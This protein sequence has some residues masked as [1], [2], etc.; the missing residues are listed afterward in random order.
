MSYSISNSTIENL[1]SQI[2]IVDVIGSCVPLKRAGSNYKGVC[3]F[4]N[5]KTP[6]FVVSEQKQ[7]F[8]CFGCGATGNVI[9]FVMMYYNMNF[10]EAVEKLAGEYGITIE[11]KTYG[12][13]LDIYYKTNKLAAQFFYRAFT[14]TANKGYAYMKRRGISPSTLKKFGIGYADESWHSLVDFLSSQGI[15]KKIMLELGLAAESKGRIYDKF[16]NRVMF[17]IINTSGKV[18][19]FGGR[20]IASEDNPKYLNSPE[21]KVFKKKNNL[22]GLNISRQSVGK[23]KFIILVEGYMDTISLFQSGIENVAASLGTAL[24]ENQ[25]RLIKRY[26]NSVVL[27]YDADQAGQKATLRGIEILRNESCKVKVLHVTDGK[28]P[29]EFVKQNGKT[30]FLE[31]IEKSLSYGEYRLKAARNGLD[32]SKDDQKLEYMKRAASILRQLS[33]LEQDMYIKK[34]AHEINVSE[35][36]LRMETAG[37]QK[38]PPKPNMQRKQSENQEET[39]IKL[40]SI[41]R[42][43]LRLVTRSEE[44]ISKVRENIFLLETDSAREIF[45]AMENDYKEHGQLDIKRALDSL[46][47]AHQQILTE[48]IENIPAGGS[49]DDI[50]AECIRR[51]RLRKLKAEEKKILTMFELADESD[52]N[53][54]LT[55]LME[56]LKHIQDE[57]QTERMKG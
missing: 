50:F 28:D 12:E 55:D 22:Y 42:D 51:R 21:S 7:I 36:A 57:I 26:T 19:G 10:L 49:E 15:D 34:L 3:P 48:I 20:A 8:T 4:H 25:A 6:S 45:T 27:S 24:T 37:G 29:D 16:R 52:S 33:P 14:E 30:A 44:Y 35:G 47:S 9:K 43:V 23:E 13:N 53:I 32:L 2:N 39:S 41:E 56:K 40:T 18:I 11:R 1:L 46:D 31:L 17:P 54:N 5:E 38:A